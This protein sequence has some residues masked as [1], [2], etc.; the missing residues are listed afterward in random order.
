MLHSLW[1]SNVDNELLILIKTVRG[2]GAEPKNV[3]GLQAPQSSFPVTPSPQWWHPVYRAKGETLW[4][5]IMAQCK[6]ACHRVGNITMYDGPTVLQN[7]LLSCEDGAA[8]I[9]QSAGT[10]QN[11]HA[12]IRHAG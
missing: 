6:V 2:L 12:E 8:N 9:H 7:T 10:S 3:S 4:I 11:I 1:G 5:G